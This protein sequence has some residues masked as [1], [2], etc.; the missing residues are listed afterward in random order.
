M[1]SSCS[2]AASR[3]I[4]NHQ[5]DGNGNGN[6]V[7]VCGPSGVSK[8]RL[9]R[10]LLRKFQETNR[11]GF[12]VSHTTRHPRKSEVDSDHYHFVTRAEFLKKVTNGDFLEYEKVHGNWYATSKLSL[13]AVRRQGKICILDIDAKGAH[14][15][16]KCRQELLPGM[17]L[18]R[19]FLAPPSLQELERRLRQ[20]GTETETS[21]KTRMQDAAREIQDGFLPGNFDK[22]IV[23]DDLQEAFN[24]MVASF[25]DWFPQLR[26]NDLG[27]HNGSR[28]K[29]SRL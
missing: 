4:R 12:V 23:N 24:E 14:T 29:I 20:R 28:N 27:M 1:S 11:L 25:Q 17:N 15:L 2:T 7:I 9:I 16:Q 19:I 21:L 10:M 13:D 5:L 26:D 3:P 8:G 22:V 18:K 6:A